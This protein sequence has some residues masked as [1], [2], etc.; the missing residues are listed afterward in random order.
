MGNVFNGGEMGEVW[1]ARRHGQALSS[2]LGH[3]AQ[4]PGHPYRWGDEPH[5]DTQGIRTRKIQKSVQLDHQGRCVV[6]RGL[7][8]KRHSGCPFNSHQA[9][10]GRAAP[11]PTGRSA[12]NTRATSSQSSRRLQ[13]DREGLFEAQS[14][15][16]KSLPNR[17]M[18]LVAQGAMT[19]SGSELS[20]GVILGLAQTA[21]SI[22][23]AAY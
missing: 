2:Q 19:A 23:L 9:R 17:P 5:R 13:H 7:D 14:E 6:H 21:P 8:G 22:F 20:R 3:R 4:C 11:L 1:T 16:A 15:V 12:R 18:P 10:P